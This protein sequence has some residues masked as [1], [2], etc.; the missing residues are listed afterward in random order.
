MWLFI[1]FIPALVALVR[2]HHN[3]LAICLLN[4]FLGWTLIGWIVALVWSAMKPVTT[5][6]V[7]ER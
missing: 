5:T 2:N 3:K 7:L 1:Y 6:V 4:V